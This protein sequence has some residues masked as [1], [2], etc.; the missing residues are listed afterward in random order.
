MTKKTAAAPTVSE[1][2]HS[3]IKTSTKETAVSDAKCTDVPR[4]IQTWKK[5]KTKKSK[6][7]R[8]HIE[9]NKEMAQFRVMI[10][11]RY[12]LERRPQCCSSAEATHIR[13]AIH[14]KWWV[15][16]TLFYYANYGFQL[17]LLMTRQLPSTTRGI[18]H[19]EVLF[20]NVNSRQS[21]HGGCA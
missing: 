16:P 18:L 21:R 2:P 11:V 4:S 19:K 1:N 7:R 13:S 5:N 9:I 6:K 10:R 20:M 15:Q 8:S 14:K 17:V 12:G 3:I